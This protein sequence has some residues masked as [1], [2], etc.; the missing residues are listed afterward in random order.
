[1]TKNE[2]SKKN[3]GKKAFYTA[4]LIFIL[5][6]ALMPLVLSQLLLANAAVPANLSQYEWV[7]MQANQYSHF[8][9]GPAPSSPDVLW[10]R[11]LTS[12][13]SYPAAFNGM[14]FATQGNN[15]TALDPFTGAIIY[16]V[17]VPPVVP[18]RSTSAAYVTKLDD[19][20]MFVIS[21]TASV[22]REN[23]SQTLTA[24]WAFRGYSIADGALLWS[25]PAQIGQTS[26]FSY[27]P[28]TKMIYINVGN[29]TG[30][31]GTQNPGGI[32]AWQFS[33]FAREPTLAWTYV[34]FGGISSHSVGLYG[35]GKVYPGSNEPHQVA[36][37]GRTGKVVWDLDLNGLPYYGGTYENGVLYK[38]LLDNTFVAINTTTG[39]I[40]W[41]YNPH[42]Y[43]FWCSATATGYGMVYELNVDGYLYALDQ[44]TGQVVWKYLGPGQYYPG[45]VE[46]A[47][48]KVYACTGQ[49][50]PSPL[51]PETSRSEYSCLDAFTGKV[52]WQISKEFGSGPSDN[53]LIAY[54]N[55]YGLDSSILYCYGPAKDWAMFGS[56]P[57]HTASGFGGPL[58]M[59]LSWKFQTGGAVVSSPAA[60]KGKIYIGS[61]DQTWYCLDANTGAKVWGF[62]VGYPI[63]S[64]AA[65][66]NDRV[67]TGADDGF[68]YCL[69]ANT[70]AQIWKTPAP[71]QVLPIMTGTFPQYTSSPIVS[72]GKVYAGSVDANLYCLD[73]TTGATIWKLPTSNSILS[74]P[75]LIEGDG[76][77]IASVDGYVYK[78][79]PANGEIIWK[80]S[81]PIG[82][83]L[84]MEGT[85]V[86]GNGLVVIGS[87]AARNSPA[88]MG[89]M[90]ALNATTGAMVWKNTA[91]PGS[92]N[93]QPIWTAL[94]VVE[95]NL[96]PVF[97]YA[98]FFSMDCVNATSGK[99][100]WSSFL[101]REHMGQPAYADGKI[102]VSSNTFGP[103]VINSTSGAKLGYI[104]A[105]GE[106]EG[107][108]SV[109]QNNIYFG[110][111]DGNV[112]C[113]KQ[114][115]S[116]TTTYGPFLTAWVSKE[117]VQ[118]NEQVTITGKENPI[119]PNSQVTVT[120]SRPDSSFVDL[121]AKTD[122][123]GTFTVT[124]T[125]ETA[126][127]WQ[128]S[129]W[130][131]CET[132]SGAVASG[133]SQTLSF[134][135]AA[136]APT[137]TPSPTPP[138]P[139]P[140]PSPPPTPQPTTPTPPPPANPTPTNSPSATPTATNT[141]DMLPYAAAAVVV[142]IVVVAVV[143]V[144]L[145]RRK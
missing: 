119:V 24:Q 60:V 138:P 10:T 52:I 123:T 81:T 73:S 4:T 144:L 80:I 97:Y 111:F 51:T 145:R 11:R 141:P 126:G 47:D 74:T 98:D 3:S 69:D 79:N 56:D 42:D 57:A 36:L 22:V 139:T 118:V 31:G 120:L 44:Q 142:A 101:T 106:I 37:D 41:S 15:I 104:D 78:V 38:G 26:R 32:Q 96:G 16:N 19:K 30:R 114:A 34:A 83:E 84:A 140:T 127:T 85:P 2:P 112:Y 115:S 109:Y 28:E 137:P 102:Y 95:P 77:Y 43:G 130:Y 89:Q 33:D 116:G 8:S 133:N 134:E 143:A 66:V 40:I 1:M 99:V 6:L 86:V 76:L 131:S 88:G 92:G 103:Y 75:T 61:D 70:G 105:G 90:Y 12:G 135:V 59:T 132:I 136:P 124:Y 54:G 121:P 25:M 65:V 23:Q 87:G 82:L 91:L 129:A 128:A 110:S 14:L 21:T 122:S 29:T 125:P 108:I 5:T 27:A 68:F 94:Y 63:R 72:G 100:L 107:S 7:G 20:Y 71:G 13:G 117:K 55:L 48:G 67:Y 9:S 93:L 18:G 46:V 113:V 64:S 17:A 49:K 35:D 53:N 39:K 50:N 62:S 45:S 58:N